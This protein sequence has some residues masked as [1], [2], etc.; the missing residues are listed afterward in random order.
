MHRHRT[1]TMLN[2]NNGTT[3]YNKWFRIMLF[4]LLG[5]TIA[6]L[7]IKLLS[8]SST[9]VIIPAS[10]TAEANKLGDT[11]LTTTG[12][13]NS[14]LPC[15]NSDLLLCKTNLKTC[16]E[17]HQKLKIS[18]LSSS[19]GSTTSICTS[20]LTSHLS[21]L[22]YRYSL[23]HPLL[24]HAKFVSKTHGIVYL[25]F[26]DKGFIDMTLSFICNV[27]PFETVLSKCI[28]IC[29]DT[30]SY[31][32][33]NKFSSE[34]LKEPLR[35]VLIQYTPEGKGSA[36]MKYGDRAYHDMMFFRTGL[37]YQLLEQGV[38]LMLIE[39]DVVWHGDPTSV[40]LA[41]QGDIVSGNDRP[42]DQPK[43]ISH[44]FS[45]FRP[46]KRLLEFV[47]RVHKEQEHLMENGLGNEQ[48]NMDILLHGEFSDV[49]IVF[50]DEQR[51]INGQRF[52]DDIPMSTSNAPLVRQNNWVIGNDVKVA[53]AKKM[54]WW[55]VDDDLKYCNATAMANIKG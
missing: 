9:S 48:T 18:H 37:Y 24:Q 42:V 47:H 43:G 44:G 13:S 5:G 26:L 10:T 23:E 34:N 17:Q 30:E 33:L 45:F 29:A 35:V 25:Q 6:V 21:P 11:V 8:Y 12:S 50:L 20:S 32:A 31:N 40:I 2:N 41:T 46:S 39:S 15:D 19:T 16:M 54:G 52:E 27:L 14:V 38:H 4:V 49:E 1:I 55:F 22:P 3:T 7:L 51:F 53:R 28:F 36:A